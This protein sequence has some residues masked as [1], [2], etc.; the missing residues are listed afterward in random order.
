[1]DHQPLH[2]VGVQFSSFTR[3][4]QLCCEEI[5]VQYTLGTQVDGKDY[6]LR[7]PEL[8]RI[9]PFCKVPVLLDAGRPL[10]E[11]QTICRYLDNQYNQA[12]LQPQDAWQ[13][14]EV[15]QWCAA[16][17]TYVDKAIVR[18]YLLEFLFPKGPNGSVREDVVA[19]AIPDVIQVVGILEQQ[20][21]GKDFLVGNQFTL[22]DILL[23]PMITYLVNAP[24][25]LDL[26]SKDSVLRSYARRI[27]ARPA[28][29][30]V[31]IPIVK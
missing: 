5:G 15:D 9:N 30:N 8:G 3:A 24:H 2:I 29:K 27:L 28:A 4:V 6:A 10:Y 7:T 21:G 1:M 14:A 12:R 13:K 31:F 11:T 19:A 18:N 16:I 26:V 25:N 23:A 20:L 17:T 22:A